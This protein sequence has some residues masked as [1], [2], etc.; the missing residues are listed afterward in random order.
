MTI[1]GHQSSSLQLQVTVAILELIDENAEGA[2]VPREEP[3]EI[4]CTELT[5]MSSNPDC[6]LVRIN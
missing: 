4:I 3:C 6:I 5:N 1:R 2:F